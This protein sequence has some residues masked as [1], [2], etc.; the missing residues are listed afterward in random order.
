MPEQ[1]TIDPSLQSLIDIAISDLTARLSIEPTD[2][3]V[4]S[5]APVE[6]PDQGLGCP[7]PGMLYAQVTVD[8]ALIELAVSSNLYRYHAG[9]SRGP[10]LCEK[11]FT[12]E[13]L[14]PKP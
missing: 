2:V 14:P 10:F 13:P 9:G 11:T 7:Q 12:A 4:I 1:G 8:G 3:T 6:W 5:A